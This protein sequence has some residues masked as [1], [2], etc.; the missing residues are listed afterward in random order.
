[1]KRLGKIL[2]AGALVASLGVTAAMADYN[3]GYKYFNKYVKAKAGIKGT[4]FIKMLEIKSP[5]D[6]D[7]LFKDGGKPLVEKLEKLNKKK[8]AKYV[9][10]ILKKHANDLKDFLK[11]MAAGKIPAGC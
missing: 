10:K 6:V 3:K 7:A 8:A 2:V 5:D 9:K 11:G 4:D 1:M